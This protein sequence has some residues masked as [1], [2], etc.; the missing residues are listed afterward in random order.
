MEHPVEVFVEDPIEGELDELDNLLDL[1]ASIPDQIIPRP[2]VDVVQAKK[3]MRIIKACM[4]QPQGQLVYIQLFESLSNGD[5]I[6]D[7]NL[8]AREEI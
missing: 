8:R 7:Q 6:G 1:A 2:R 5:D 3:R 4:N